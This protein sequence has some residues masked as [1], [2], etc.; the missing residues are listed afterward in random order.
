MAVTY[1][2]AQRHIFRPTRFSPCSWWLISAS[3]ICR[4]QWCGS[5]RLWH[6]TPEGTRVCGRAI[7]N[8]QRILTKSPWTQFRSRLEWSR[9]Y[10]LL[11]HLSDR[12]NSDHWCYDLNKHWY[13][14]Q[15]LVCEG[16]AWVSNRRIRYESVNAILWGFA[17]SAVS[18]PDRSSD[19]ATGSCNWPCAEREE[20]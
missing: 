15:F 9:Q 5:L 20:V 16:E 12:G 6:V 7:P 2:A 17:A 4:S 3:N 11:M 8:T 1:L 18:T 13:W 19:K 10:W 14:L